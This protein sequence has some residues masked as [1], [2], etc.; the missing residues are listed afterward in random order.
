[1]S[2]YKDSIWILAKISSRFHWKLGMGGE[3]GVQAPRLVIELCEFSN[4]SL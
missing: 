2:R 3:P 1:M 4:K